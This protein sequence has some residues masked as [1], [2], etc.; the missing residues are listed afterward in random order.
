MKIP[1][2]EWKLLLYCQANENTPPAN[3]NTPQPMK[4]FSQTNENTRQPT[5]T[6]L[7]TNEN[8][9]QSM[10]TLPQN[11]WKYTAAYKKRIEFHLQL[12][13]HRFLPRGA[14]HE[15]RAEGKLRV[16]TE[17]ASR[18]LQ[19][20]QVQ[21]QVQYFNHKLNLN[22]KF[23]YNSNFNFNFKSNFNL[24][25][26]LNINFKFKLIINIKFNFKFI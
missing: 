21:A 19:L 26:D 4:T 1:R 12:L 24:K 11:Q 10:N 25:F 3:E 17:S 16:P 20:Q 5:K 7:Q 2:L 23:K 14:L 18:R 15:R 9:R 8:T 6:L 13:A 22:F